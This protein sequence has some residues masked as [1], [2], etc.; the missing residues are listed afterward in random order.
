MDSVPLVGVRKDAVPRL[1]GDWKVAT[2]SRRLESRRS[3]APGRTP[4]LGDW[5]VAAPRRCYLR[6]VQVSKF[7]SS[8]SQAFIRTPSISL[9]WAETYPR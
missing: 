3:Q 7:Q 2:P 5:K 4:L 1:S 6:R 8:E 9:E